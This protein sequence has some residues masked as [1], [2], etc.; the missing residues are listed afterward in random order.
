MGWRRKLTCL[1]HLQR[2]LINN[3]HSNRLGIPVAA[4][5]L[6]TNLAAAEHPATAAV[7][8]LLLLVSTPRRLLVH[9]VTSP[10]LVRTRAAAS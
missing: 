10:R 7:S 4:A 9:M 1:T 3:I 2:T 6:P 8:T 5:H